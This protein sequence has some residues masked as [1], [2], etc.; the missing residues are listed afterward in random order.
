MKKG[1]GGIKGSGK[2]Y[3]FSY[4]IFELGGG[5]RTVAG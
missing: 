4:R 5:N 3:R 1:L 2:V